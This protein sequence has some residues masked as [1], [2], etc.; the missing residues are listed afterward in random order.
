MTG[1]NH[2]GEDETVLRPA[3]L[4]G[5]TLVQRL[6]T[7]LWSTTTQQ[8]QLAPQPSSLRMV[9]LTDVAGVYTS[10]PKQDAMATLIPHIAVHDDGRL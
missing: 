4:S 10:D 5:D 9:F 6:A 3:I 1:D 7:G 2:N 8:Q